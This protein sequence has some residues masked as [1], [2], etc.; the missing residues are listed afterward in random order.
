M[1]WDVGVQE[2]LV[3][4]QRTIEVAVNDLRSALVSEHSRILQA[5]ETE[6][7]GEIDALRSEL[8]AISASKEQDSREPSVVG[9]SG[10]STIDA[11]AVPADEPV[12]LRPLRSAAAHPSS[13]TVFADGD[14]AFSGSPGQ[15]AGAAGTHQEAGPDCFSPRP[16][17]SVVDAMA[18]LGKCR[19]SLGEEALAA[20][21]HNRGSEFRESYSSA[22]G[23][24]RVHVKRQY[25]LLEIG[26][27]AV[28]LVNAL[29]IGLSADIGRGAKFWTVV[30]AI[31]ALIYSLEVIWRLRE[32]GF[33]LY[34]CGSDWTW[35][36]FETLLAALAWLEVASG[37]LTDANNS[38]TSLFRVLRLVRI[39]KILRVAR[40]HIFC[41]LM[42]MVNGAM[43]S[44]MTLFYSM[45]LICIP[46]YIVSLVLRETVGTD[47]RAGDGSENFVNL[48]I[49]FFTM[50]RCIVAMDCSDD[51]G[52][53]IFVKLTTESG[54]IYG[55]IYCLTTVLLVF[56]LFN[57]IVA[58]YVENTVAAARYSDLN[59]K[60]H[61]LRDKEYFRTRTE[62]LLQYIWAVT[63]NK[64]VAHVDWNTWNL[65]EVAHVEMTKEFFEE[66]CQD[67]HFQDL[68]RDLDIADEDQID[69]FETLDMDG[70]GTID[71]EEL[72]MG[73]AKLRGEARRADLVATLLIARSL[74]SSVQELVRLVQAER[75]DKY[76]EQEEQKASKQ[77]RIRSCMSKSYT[78]TAS[79]SEVPSI[80]F[81]HAAGSGLQRMLTS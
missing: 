79:Q 36:I 76:E 2:G 14:P 12:G 52:K 58:I 56:G 57:V 43:G 53:P 67:P 4:F 71:V 9:T 3:E 7:L 73:I 45:I 6:L 74:Q 63:Q 23:L 24:T 65:D 20:M 37:L 68:L 18:S 64:H 40:L 59:H 51:Q 47:P 28:I 30:D 8:K 48:P 15:L 77:A 42:A 31:F 17:L 70:G 35:N 5:R 46:L 29:T 16:S 60:R 19:S 39:T 38:K 41:D 32:L 27:P 44:C 22:N 25:Y 72:I 1:S 34:M 11:G 26:M 21:Q 75:A 50:F 54:W 80:R 55:T 13:Q 33:R 69:L 61:R 49:A 66:L 78:R 10:T 62:E 81:T